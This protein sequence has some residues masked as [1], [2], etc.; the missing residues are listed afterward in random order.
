MHKKFLEIEIQICADCG[1][2]GQKSKEIEPY[3]HGS[4]GEYEMIECP[5][6]LGSGI[7]KITRDI[8]ITITPY[9]PKIRF[10]S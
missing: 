4:S 1:G 10:Q 5:T 2:E 8:T 7:V 3:R 9:L 6:C